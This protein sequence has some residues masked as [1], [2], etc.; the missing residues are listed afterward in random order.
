MIGAFQ[1]KAAQ[2]PEFRGFRVGTQ[3]PVAPVKG[4]VVVSFLDCFDDVSGRGSR[5]LRG[6]PANHRHQDRN[7]SQEKKRRLPAPLSKGRQPAVERHSKHNSR[8]PFNRGAGDS[9]RCPRLDRVM[10]DHFAIPRLTPEYPDLIALAWSKTKWWRGLFS[11][12]STDQEGWF[13]PTSQLE[14]P[15]H[16]KSVRQSTG[17]VWSRSDKL[18]SFSSGR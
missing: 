3:Q 18:F 14:V 10:D 15:P 11:G 17:L 5:T 9:Q 13:E 2:S 16:P 8:R 7:D 6:H 1:G 4:I 12:R